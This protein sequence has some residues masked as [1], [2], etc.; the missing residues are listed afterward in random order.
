LHPAPTP[1][2][3]LAL[4]R[5]S[6]ALPASPT[7]EASRGSSPP[8]LA[9]LFP[10]RGRSA[11]HAPRRS[12]PRAAPP[13]GPRFP[14]VDPRRGRAAPSGPQAGA[15]GPRDSNRQSADGGFPWASAAFVGPV[16]RFRPSPSGLQNLEA[17]SGGRPANHRPP[18][19]R[20]PPGGGLSPCLDGLLSPSNGDPS[21]PQRCWLRVP[22]GFS[23]SADRAKRQLLD[24]PLRA[25]AGR[26]T[27]AG[28]RVTGCADLGRH[29]PR[30]AQ[31]LA[32]IPST[33]LERGTS[34][35]QAWAM[36]PPIRASPLAARHALTALTQAPSPPCV[37]KAPR[38]QRPATAWG[39][40]SCVARGAN[41]S[42][43]ITCAG[44]PRF[45]AEIVPDYCDSCCGPGRGGT[46]NF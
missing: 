14:R 24:G 27:L 3:N 40:S 30:E 31:P 44:G 12:L 39:A 1:R 15:V 26:R 43:A 16:G 45:G 35:A 41:R 9:F 20:R 17:I 42:H 37:P 28:P 8:L 11:A 2:G 18:G 4:R 29:G 19:F 34:L 21:T 38:Q 22:F 7:G 13:A 33:P 10:R 25:G 23:L 6:A 46:A 32:T 5:P 36:V